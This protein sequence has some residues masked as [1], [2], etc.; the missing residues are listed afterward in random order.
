M[1]DDKIQIDLNDHQ[2]S[3]IQSPDWNN[4]WAIPTKS[5][6][7]REFISS[8]TWNCT[9][10]NLTLTMS[11]TP[12]F[13]AYSWFNQLTVDDAIAICF[14]DKRDQEVMRLL[15]CELQLC[16]HKCVMDRE[17]RDSDWNELIH[18]LKL[19][20]VTVK[21]FDNDSANLLGED[22]EMSNSEIILA[23]NT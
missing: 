22:W 4:F 17:D 11:E 5:T 21:K 1:K 23:E 12:S 10:K 18:E 6:H 13:A 16:D 15:F 20:Y 7:L 14:F 2:T 9:T 19:S 8:V 3:K